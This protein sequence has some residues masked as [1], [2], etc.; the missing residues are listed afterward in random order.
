[1]YI[2]SSRGIPKKIEIKQRTSKLDIKNNRIE[3]INLSLSVK[4]KG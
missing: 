4:E 3:N 2:K 1:M